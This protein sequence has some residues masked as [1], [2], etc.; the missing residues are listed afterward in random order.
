MS[1]LTQILETQQ[2]I[3]RSDE[4]YT[5]RKQYLTASDIGSVLGLNPYQTRQETLFKKCDA[6]KPFTGNIATEHGQRYE[7]E[8][9]DEYARLL[10][11][12]SY[13]VGLI[14]Y[15]ALN[16]NTFVNNIDCSFL[17]GS[18]DGVTTLC[19]GTE[20]NAIEVKS[21]FRR[22]I[23]YHEIPEHYYP[24]LQINLHIL[25]VAMGDFIEYVPQGHQRAL[26]PKMNV[27]RIYKD[28][29]W[30]QSVLPSLFDFW[31]EVKLYRQVGIDKFPYGLD[32]L[33]TSQI[34]NTDL[35]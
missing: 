16:S 20:L 18:A 31:E 15:A 19:D 28:D 5:A 12:V 3:Q 8:A 35:T 6:G 23:I 1:N 32:Y 7:Q 4:W 22:S 30:F 29:A 9:I 34:N 33:N 21:P 10:G 26:K 17:A 27:V 25:N 2:F 24:Q 14:P 13:E 11:R